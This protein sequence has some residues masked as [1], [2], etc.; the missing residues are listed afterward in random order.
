MSRSEIENK[1]VHALEHGGVSSFARWMGGKSSKFLADTL[2]QAFDKYLESYEDATHPIDMTNK[3]QLSKEDL[4]KASYSA[5][6]KHYLEQGKN[7]AATQITWISS[8]LFFKNRLKELEEEFGKISERNVEAYLGSGIF[9]KSGGSQH[10]IKIRLSLKEA[11]FGLLFERFLDDAAKEHRDKNPP[12]K[13]TDEWRNVEKLI[14]WRD[15][16]TFDSY[17]MAQNIY[18]GFMFLAPVMEARGSNHTGLQN[19]D[20]ENDDDNVVDWGKS[21]GGMLSRACLREDSPEHVDQKRSTNVA[22]RDSFFAHKSR[23]NP[24]VSKDENRNRAVTMKMGSSSE[25]DAE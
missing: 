10:L 5:C 6:A 23:N 1:I 21:A 3:Y 25:S 4:S 15:D 8:T 24:H 13:M 12:A 19:D 16:K 7:F 9:R 2:S 11:S 18:N 14:E 22:G 17:A 20:V